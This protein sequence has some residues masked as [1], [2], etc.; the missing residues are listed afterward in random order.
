M[1]KSMF[2]VL[3][4]IVVEIASSQDTG[5][6]STLSELN[7]E[8]Q[9]PDFISVE[10]G[11][12][13]LSTNHRV[14]GN[15][16]L[17]WD[18]EAND[19]LRIE[20]D[21][22]YRPQKVVD[23]VTILG[24]VYEETNHPMAFTIPVYSEKQQDVT[25]RVEFG[26]DEKVN[27]FFDILLKFEGWRKFTMSYD[28]GH[29]RGEP[30][31]GMNFVRFKISG[32]V[33]GTIYLDQLMF[34][35]RKDPRSIKASP[36]IPKQKFHPQR[37]SREV[38]TWHLNQPW[39]PLQSSVTHNQKKSFQRIEDR[40]YDLEWGGRITVKKLSDDKIKQIE[41]G[42]QHFNINRTNGYIN[43]LHLDEGKNK[44]KLNQ[45]S[46]EIGLAYQQTQNPKQKELLAQMG[47]DL[48]EHAID[49]DNNITWYNGRGFAEGCFFL[50]DELKKADLFHKTIDF[51]RRKYAFPRFYN[52]D[53][54]N[55]KHDSPTFSSDEI[56]TDSVGLIL[57]ILIMDDSPEK[58]RDMQHFISFYSNI[59]FNYSTGISAS[60]KPDGSHFH[61]ANA[62]LTRY[63][64]YTMPVASKVIR[65]FSDTDF[66]IYEDAHERMKKNVLVRRFYRTKKWFPYAFSHNRIR[67]L[68]FQIFDDSRHLALA[69][70]PDGTKDIDEEMAAVY[71]RMMDGEELPEDAKVFIEMGIQPEK[72]PQGHHT[73]SYFAKS[74][75]RKDDWMAVVGA[76]SRYIY[77]K[78]NW[79]WH[80]TRGNVKF[81]M[82]ENWGSLELIYPDKKGLEQVDNGRTL[83]GWDWTQIPGV[84]SINAPLDRI[85]IQTLKRGDE[86]GEE[87]LRSDQPFVGGL[88]FSDGNGVFVAK[89]R[90]H[91]KYHLESF[92]ATKSWFFFGDLIVCLGSGI[93]NDLPEYSTHTSLFQN[94]F[95]VTDFSMSYNSE[96]TLS[97]EPSE[98]T[99]DGEFDSWIVD[100]RKVGYYLPSG[101]ALKMTYGY[102]KSRDF[103]DKEDTRAKLEKAWIEHGNAPDGVGYE[104]AVKMNVDSREMKRF[105]ENQA[106]QNEYK[107]IQAD[108]TA[109]IVAHE[110]TTAYSV[111][112]KN[113]ELNV[114]H[115]KGVSHSGMFMIKDEGDRIKLAVSDPDLRLYEGFNTDV[116]IRL[117]RKEEPSYSNHWQAHASIAS[118]IKVFLH[119]NWEMASIL[120]GGGKIIQQSNG[121]TVVE[122][123]CKDGLTNELVLKK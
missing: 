19:A 115:L 44:T 109:H 61:H 20:G 10:N 24:D 47:V 8:N 28:R 62:A 13:S 33:G 7:F 6:T 91:H 38:Q 71:L 68:D 54:V 98:I 11:K 112:N 107:V 36:L 53:V 67:P 84:T 106:S 122:F 25:L 40:I 52:E 99:N 50:K 59:A 103:Q 18:F 70:T 46:K 85:K 30:K 56:Y 49:A 41:E 105:A 3:L 43:G 1:K 35:F 58:V 69:G 80:K 57:S 14:I 82:F 26:T 72:T 9:L 119:G 117:H 31:E 94:S 16:G 66:R 97:D 73:L 2:S 83:E 60:F 65:I 79:S 123:I 5:Q 92:Y 93:R 114:G 21:V 45:L 37:S 113:Y 89:I 34:S 42:Y 100:S 108:D 23:T 95:D 88:D 118:T 32:D 77:Q 29:L 64:A 81:G 75:H 39:F 86:M 15:K 90:G 121:I 48:I 110:N 120:K 104:Y 78:E 101:Q 4:L 17:R 51:L 27:C 87:H 96:K 111:F 63:G 76:H 116:D 22:G 102:Q 55:G 74:I 12:I